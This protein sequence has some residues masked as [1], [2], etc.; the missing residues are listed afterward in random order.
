LSSHMKT[1]FSRFGF[2]DYNHLSGSIPTEIGVLTEL[3]YLNLSKYDGCLRS[4]RAQIASGLSSHVKTALSPFRFIGSN[5]LSGSL[6]TEI[7]ILLD[8]ELLDLGRYSL[9]GNSDASSIWT[10]VC[11][12]T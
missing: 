6:P 8:L 2:I 5:Y 11:H 9:G 3:T 7:G 10:L 4:F 12:L 1:A